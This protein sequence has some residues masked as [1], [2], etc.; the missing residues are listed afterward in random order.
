[1]AARLQ[2]VEDMEG[3]S[4]RD[5]VR[6]AEQFVDQVAP[7]TKGTKHCPVCMATC[8][9]ESLGSHDAEQF[10]PDGARH[11]GDSALSCLC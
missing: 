2:L 11:R 6:D 10:V 8:C 1:M 9:R 3:D 5:A 4:E 7:G